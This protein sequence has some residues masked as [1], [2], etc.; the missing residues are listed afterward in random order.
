M[1]VFLF[2]RECPFHGKSILFQG[3]S[4]CVCVCRG[5]GPTFAWEPN[6]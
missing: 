3:S 4:V 1:P 5:G 6:C 2:Y